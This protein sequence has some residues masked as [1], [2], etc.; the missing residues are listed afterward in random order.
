MF[1]VAYG[2]SGVLGVLGVRDGLGSTFGQVSSNNAIAVIRSIQAF[3][4]IDIIGLGN[5]LSML[6]FLVEFR[7]GLL[8]LPSVY[9]HEGY[10][11]RSPIGPGEVSVVG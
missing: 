2:V 3:R 7:S 4:G 6:L 5:S 8:S 11:L 1:R 9:E 10:E